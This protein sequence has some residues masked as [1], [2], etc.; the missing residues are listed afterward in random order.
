MTFEQLLKTNNW[1]SISSMFLK[2]YPKAESEID[3]YKNVFHKLVRMS[4]ERTDMSIVIAKIMDDDK[5]FIEV[6]GLHNNPKRQDEKYLQ[7]IEYV[8]WR[9]WLGMDICKESMDSY[10]NEEIIVR[11]LY[12]MTFLG[13]NDDEFQK[14]I[15]R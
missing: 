7:G 9:K 11:C 15:A 2:I 10:S 14:V 1:Q 4:P 3:G 6:C 5:E 13:F 12:E 8:P